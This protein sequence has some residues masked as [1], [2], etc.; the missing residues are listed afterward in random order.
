MMNGKILKRKRAIR[1]LVGV[2]LAALLI[3]ISG[4]ANYIR[5]TR[6]PILMYHHVVADETESCNSMT[7]TVSRLRQ[8]MTYLKQNGY[9]SLLPADLVRIYRGDMPMPQKPVMI[10]FDDGYESNYLYAY[11]IL[12]E[13]N[14]RAVVSVI[15]GNIREEGPADMV[16]ATPLTWEEC[17]IMYQ[18]GFVDIGCHTYALHNN[19]SGGVPH[20]D[21]RDGVQRLSG[22]KR[23]A[24][25]ARVGGD[26]HDGVTMI[27]KQVG[28]DCI[29]FSYPFGA[30]DG[31]FDELIQR[32][33]IA[34]STTTVQR[35][36]YL[37][38]GTYHLPRWRVTMET[39]IDAFL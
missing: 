20:P 7:V 8:D 2:L 18:S 24:Y 31:W 39:N 9:T 14:L 25:R 23:E 17:Q 22:E 4:A 28:N 1:I 12:R 32:E 15:A 27:E 26:L 30:G 6:I 29:Y 3:G 36:A 34:V 38:F 33:G 13:N 21:G 5:R 19:D 11:P 35:N 16:G 10:T 37:A